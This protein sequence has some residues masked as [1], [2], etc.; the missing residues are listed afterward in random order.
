MQL[1]I[2][3]NACV[4]LLH[5]IFFVFYAWSIEFLVVE[6]IYVELFLGPVFVLTI[7]FVKLDQK[8]RKIQHRC[9]FFFFCLPFFLLQRDFI[10]QK[11]KILRNVSQKL[12]V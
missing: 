5:F 4:L 11:F 7:W 6:V 9:D 8:V 10:D 12:G 2:K 3:C 1:I